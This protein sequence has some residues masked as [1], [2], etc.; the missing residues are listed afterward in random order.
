MA[1][2]AQDAKKPD[3][4]TADRVAFGAC[5]ELRVPA[6]AWEDFGRDQEAGIE[7]VAI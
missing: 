7:S 2:G 6:A 1:F 3:P 5:Q 4:G